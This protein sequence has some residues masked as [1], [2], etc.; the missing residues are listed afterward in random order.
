MQR[1]PALKREG[2]LLLPL[3]LLFACSGVGSVAS[4]WLAKLSKATRQGP[5]RTK[6]EKEEKV[7]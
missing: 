2:L 5:T 3:L 4:H 7:Q 1:Y 6:S